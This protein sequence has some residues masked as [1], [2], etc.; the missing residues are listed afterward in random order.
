VTLARNGL[1]ASAGESVNDHA[2]V[3]RENTAGRREAQLG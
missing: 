3:D 2:A 1:C